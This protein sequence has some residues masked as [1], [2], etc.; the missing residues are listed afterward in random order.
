MLAVN[1]VNDCAFCTSLHGELGRMAGL[2]DK[3]GKMNSAKTAGE[4]KTLSGND[5]MVVYARK[6]GECDGRGADLEE[7]FTVLEKAVGAGSASACRAHCWFLQWGSI[8]GN[9]LLS[10]YQG[11]LVGDAKSGS[12]V[13]FE[14]AFAAYYT[15]CYVLISA[16]SLLLK[17]LPSKVP[18]VVSSALGCVLTCV[19][20]IWIVPLGVVG[21]ATAPFR[22][23]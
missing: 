14:I 9:T 22:K 5:P 8:A 7:A 13:L 23:K 11:R 19:A 18:N 4:I 6:F 2:E 15:P 17:A 1:S 3:V 21:L 12:N 20:S 10:F 16:T